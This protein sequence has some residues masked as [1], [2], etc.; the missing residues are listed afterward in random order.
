MILE[1]WWGWALQTWLQRCWFLY[2]ISKLTSRWVDRTQVSNYNKLSKRETLILKDSII[3]TKKFFY[4]SKFVQIWITIAWNGKA[5]K[6]SSLNAIALDLNETLK[7]FLWVQQ[8]Q[9]K[10]IKHWWKFVDI[11]VVAANLVES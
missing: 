11:L 3:L 4:K 8:G 10:G 2:F 1:V 9:E 6:I 5:Q 7:D